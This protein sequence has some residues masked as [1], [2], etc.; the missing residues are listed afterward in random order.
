MVDAPSKSVTLNLVASGSR[1]FNFNGYRNGA[2]T[3][4]VPVGW[5]VNVTCTNRSSVSHSCAVVDNPSATTPA[6]E[7]ASTAD[8]TSGLPPGQSAAFS[9][10]AS[11][12]GSFRIACLVTGHEDGGMWDKFIVAAADTQPQVSP[13]T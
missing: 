9:F 6:F 13:A 10:V 7:G 1:N 4:T 5:K 8:P 12:I 3:I 2:M 11:K